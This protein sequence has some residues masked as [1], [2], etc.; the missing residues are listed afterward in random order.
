ML[1]AALSLVPAPAPAPPQL[2]LVTLFSVL[3]HTPVS[4]PF[5]PCPQPVPVLCGRWRHAHCLFAGRTGLNTVQQYV[6][7]PPHPHGPGRMRHNKTHP[8]HLPRPGRG[9]PAHFSSSPS[10]LSARTPTPPGY[11]GHAHSPHSALL[12]SYHRPCEHAPAVD[13]RFCRPKSVPNADV[14]LAGQSCHSPPADRL[15]DPR[16]EERDNHQPPSN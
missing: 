3:P 6:Q 1:L 15:A 10:T 11:S 5:R 8:I 2:C 9:P 12:T 14:R 13:H 7:Y 4:K 16:G